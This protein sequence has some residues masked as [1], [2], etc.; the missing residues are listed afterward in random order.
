[1]LIKTDF[2]LPLRPKIPKVSPSSIVKLISF[3]TSTPLKDF[4]MFLRVIKFIEHHLLYILI[5]VIILNIN[6][7]FVLKISNIKI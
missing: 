3:K 4:V 1:M 6:K 5:I 2:P 7:T